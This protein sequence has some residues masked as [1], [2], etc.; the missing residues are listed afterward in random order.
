MSKSSKSCAINACFSL[1]PK[2]CILTLLLSKLARVFIPGTSRHIF[3]QFYTWQSQEVCKW[4]HHPRL[5]SELATQEPA[6]SKPRCCINSRKI[7][8]KYLTELFQQNYP[9]CLLPQ[10][11]SEYLSKMGIFNWNVFTVLF[12]LTFPVQPTPFQI[13]KYTRIQAIARVI[14]SGHRICPGFSNPSV[15]WCMLRLE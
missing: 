4:T 13:Q 14:A 8:M 11:F 6:L 7:E 15:I 10:E 12:N 5:W 3:R 2:H 1:K 9:Q